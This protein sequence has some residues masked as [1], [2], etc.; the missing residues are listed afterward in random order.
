MYIFYKMDKHFVLF[1]VSRK[2]GLDFLLGV[3]K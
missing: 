3:S 1:R 2:K